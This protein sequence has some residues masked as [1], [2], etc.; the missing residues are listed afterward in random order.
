MAISAVPGMKLE[1]TLF[2]ASEA[3]NRRGPKKIE[4]SSLPGASNMARDDS[5]LHFCGVLSKVPGSAVR[6]EPGTAFFSATAEQVRVGYCPPLAR[7]RTNNMRKW[8]DRH[9]V[10]LLRR[11]TVRNPSV[12]TQSNIRTLDQRLEQSR[13]NLSCTSCC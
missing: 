6:A 1:R 3:K 7:Q 12:H 13:L 4:T 2:L 11:R 5:I 9:T 10:V 8:S